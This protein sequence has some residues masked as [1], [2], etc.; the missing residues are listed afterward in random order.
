MRHKR[1]CGKIESNDAIMPQNKKPQNKLTASKHFTDGIKRSPRPTARASNPAPELSIDPLE[2]NEEPRD[3][4]A[5]TPPKKTAAGKPGDPESKQPATSEASAQDAPQRK[6]SH[7]RR[8]IIIA[9]IVSVVVVVLVAAGIMATRRSA[10]KANKRTSV[11]TVVAPAKPKTAPSPLTGVEVSP[12]RAAHP[13]YSVVIENLYPSARPQSGLS[14]AGVVYETLSE[15]GITR[16][17]AFFGDTVPPDIGPVRS[18]RT[19]FVRWGV[20]HDAPVVHAGGN[21]DALD[22]ITP[23]DMKNLDQFANG[24]YFRRIT[25]RYAPHNLYTTGEL[26][27]KLMQAR[28]F[29]AKPSFIPWLRKDDTKNATPTAAAITVDP[30]FPDYKVTYT[31]NP[32]ENDYT[33]FIRGAAD[34]DANGNVPIKPKNVVVL[35]AAV[36]YGV[37]RAKTQATYIQTVGSGSGVVFTDGKATE[38]TW[39]KPSDKARTQFFNATGK[40]VAL[41]RGQTWVTVIPLEKTVSYQ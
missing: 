23:L 26:M 14:S 34:I 16:Y 24:S 28:G 38:I 7:K 19:F 1:F 30:S 11:K 37:T 17:Q 20:E 36:S 13:V 40:E 25:S 29:N 2:N 21:I 18:L 8:T 12:E 31:Y 15:G 35:K 22:L 3:E 33:R 10:P 4:T 39:R 6:P 32:T 9:V 41:N 5:E 27:D